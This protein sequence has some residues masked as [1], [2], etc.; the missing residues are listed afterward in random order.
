MDGIR[1]RSYSAISATN[2]DRYPNFKKTARDAP[3]DPVFVRRSGARI[4]KNTVLS[5]D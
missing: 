4:A 5:V 3:L 1:V 2:R